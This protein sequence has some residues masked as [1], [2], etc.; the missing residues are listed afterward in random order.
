MIC[1]FHTCSVCQCEE[2]EIP[3][4][5]KEDSVADDVDK[6]ID[7]KFY[8]WLDKYN[9]SSSYWLVENEVDASNGIY[10]NLEKNPEAYTGYHG[11]HIWNA[12]YYENCFK[13]NST[14][15]REDEVLYKIISGLHANI[16]SHLSKNYLD[17]STNNTYFNTTMLNKRL[18][19]KPDRINNLFFLY[20]LLLNSLRRIQPLIMNYNIYTGNAEEDSKTKELIDEIYACPLLN[21]TCEHCFRSNDTIGSFL[22]VNQLDQIKSKFRNISQIIDCVG[23]QKCKL[24]GKLQIYGLATMLKILFTPNLT[25]DKLKRNELISFVNLVG[26]VSQSIKFTL[27]GA[28]L[29][30]ENM[31]GFWY[32]YCEMF[33]IILSLSLLV[34]LNL[35]FVKHKEKFSGIIDPKKRYYQRLFSKVY[36]KSGTKKN[37]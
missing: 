9:Y 18:L 27:E 7:E 31:W 10:V 25:I 29:E 12:I 8:K 2:K 4:P 15:C 34:K 30:K 20:S 36:D 32:N 16:N 23:C 24:H 1:N 5:W 14:V 26:K 13:H 33:I 28:F 19:S 6:S 3:L 11:L 35:Y 17:I 37:N 22:R 21:K